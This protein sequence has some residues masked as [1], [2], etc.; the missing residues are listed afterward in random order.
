[1][2]SQVLVLTRGIRQEAIPSSPLPLRP[3]RKSRA[4]EEFKGWLFLLSSVTFGKS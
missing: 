2:Q 4:S 3:S 1:M